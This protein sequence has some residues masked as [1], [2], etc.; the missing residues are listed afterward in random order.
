MKGLA[1][2]ISNKAIPSNSNQSV[3][4]IDKSGAKREGI[5]TFSKR[6]FKNMKWRQCKFMDDIVEQDHRIIKRRITIS[7]G[8][9]DVDSVQ[10]TLAGIEIVNIVRENQVKDSKSTAYKTFYFFW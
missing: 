7:T 9:K 6:N 8:S 5:K 1:Q 10:R 3:I 4:N 2:K